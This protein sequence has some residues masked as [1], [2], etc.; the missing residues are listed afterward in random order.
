MKD[1]IFNLGQSASDR[2]ILAQQQA[3]HQ[4]KNNSN[5]APGLYQL[6]LP[7]WANNP[8]AS[9]CFHHS[10]WGGQTTLSNAVLVSTQGQAAALLLKSTAGDD[11]CCSSLQAPPSWPDFHPHSKTLCWSSFPRGYQPRQRQIAVLARTPSPLPGWALRWARL[12]SEERNPSY[13]HFS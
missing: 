2:L 1:G 6:R 8:L 13:I 4:E 9:L 12:S 7:G 10:C 3:A 5:Y 11:T